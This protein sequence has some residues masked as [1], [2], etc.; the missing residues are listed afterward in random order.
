MQLEAAYLDAKFEGI[1]EQHCT[2]CLELHAE[3]EKKE[4]NSIASMLEFHGSQVFPA[5]EWL[6]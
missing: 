2:D 4:K 3:I 6:C 1:R 5:S